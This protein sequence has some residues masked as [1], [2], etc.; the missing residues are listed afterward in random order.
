MD[1]IITGLDYNS[2]ELLPGTVKPRPGMRYIEA[3][4]TSSP[5]PYLECAPED[6]GDEAGTSVPYLLPSPAPFWQH[7]IMDNH[8]EGGKKKK[9]NKKK[10]NKNRQR[11]LQ[12]QLQLEQDISPSTSPYISD[13]SADSPHSSPSKSLEMSPE[14]K[15]KKKEKQTKKTRFWS[16]STISLSKSYL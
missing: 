15:A 16:R 12:L 14:K 11:Q 5:L 7:Y 10:R 6:V 13:A 8:F 2:F 1:H 9:K 4:I 3:V